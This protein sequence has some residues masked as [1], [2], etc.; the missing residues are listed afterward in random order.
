MQEI[1]INDEYGGFGLSPLGEK[2]YL[3]L[4]GKK[5]YFYIQTKYKFEHGKSEYI[6]LPF[7]DK[8]LNFMFFTFTKDLGNCVINLPE[9]AEWF[10]GRDIKRDDPD[11]IKIIKKLG[12]KV[13]GK[14]ADLKIVEI[15][16][17]VDWQVEEY[18]GNE[19]ISEKHETWR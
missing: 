11:L 18:D 14:F 16:D 5:A 2:E 8:K 1:V 17:G 3:K 6:K 15:P 13:G 19:W 10:C 9:D 4:K 7:N 12:K